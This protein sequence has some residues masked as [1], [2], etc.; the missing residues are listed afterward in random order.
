MLT[1]IEIG[2]WVKTLTELKQGRFPDN[3][4][5]E[6]MEKRFIKR[7]MSRNPEDRPKDVTE[8]IGV[9]DHQIREYQSKKSHAYQNSIL[10]AIG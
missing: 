7:I 5:L 3:N 4:N 8:V 2:Q 6:E 1:I 9:I 10:A